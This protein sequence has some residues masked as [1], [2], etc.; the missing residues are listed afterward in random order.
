MT[1]RK[2]DIQNIKI[3]EGDSLESRLIAAG[4]SLGT[5]A[6]AGFVS[7]ITDNNYGFQS[8]PIIATA[9]STGYFAGSGYLLFSSNNPMFKLEK[10][11]NNF[12]NYSFL[13]LG[14]LGI[15]FL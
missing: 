7:S 12:I 4:I 10:L 13:T 5:G 1:N 14:Y 8:M 2:P 11:K 6:A 3:S 15:Y 9:I